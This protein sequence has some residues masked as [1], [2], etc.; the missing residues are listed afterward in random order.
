M[1][2][3][4]ERTKALTHMRSLAR[5]GANGD[6]ADFADSLGPTLKS[7]PAVGLE[8]V[9]ARI[10]QGD[11][12]RAKQ[13]LGDVEPH[14]GTPGE[15]LV[16][17][18]ES[19]SFLILERSAL[20]EAL[21][22]AQRALAAAAKEQVDPVDAAEGRRI[23]ARIQLSLGVFFE[24]DPATVARVVTELPEIAEVL[25][26]GG[27]L[28]ESMAA[29]LTYA[30]RLTGHSASLAAFD[31]IV[32]RATEL[33]MPE[34][35]AEALLRKAERLAKT[36]GSN[37]EIQ[38][39]LARAGRE[40]TAIR[41]VHG[42]VDVA[43]AQALLAVTREF[44][45][46][47]T[48]L[49]LYDKYLEIRHPRGAMVLLMD[50]SQLEH[51]RGNMPA[52]DTYRRQALDLAAKYGM[53]MMRDTFR[54]GQAD[55]LMRSNRYTEAIDLCQAA[56]A[57]ELPAYHVAAYQQLLATTYS[58]VGNV[59][60]ELRYATLAMDRFEA[61]GAMDS[62]SVVAAKLA[63]ALASLRIDEA[64]HE[65]VTLL[66]R[67]AD[68]D[69]QR[70]D[71]EEAIRKHELLVQNAINQFHVSPSPSLRIDL[72]AEAK[73][74]LTSAE[75][76]LPRLASHKAAQRRGGL[77]QLRG[78][79]LQSQGN[80]EG[81]EQAWREAVHT[82][83]S[84]GLKME[85]ANS[86]FIVGVMCLNRANEQLLPHFGEAEEYLNAAQQF[87][88][89]MGMRS[90]DAQARY[91]LA[92]LYSNAA[93]RAP[94]EVRQPLNQAALEHLDRAEVKLDAVRTEYRASSVL[95]T[96]KEKRALAQRS[97]RINELALWLSIYVAVDA[98]L[99]WNWTQRTKARAFNDTLSTRFEKSSTPVKAV[100]NESDSIF[101]LMEAFGTSSEVPR[102]SIEADALTGGTGEPPL[103]T[104]DRTESNVTPEDELAIPLSSPITGS[105]LHRILET[106][107]SGDRSFV[108][109]DW[110]AARGRLALCTLGQDGIP[111]MK[112]LDVPL[113]SVDDFVDSSLGEKT[114]RFTLHQNPELL[115]VLDSLIA[116]LVE[117]TNPGDCLI[118]CPTGSL[119]AIPLHALHLG[120]AP[121]LV[122]NPVVYSPSLSV[123]RYSLMQSEPKSLT[124][125]ALLGDPN[126]DRPTAAA[127][128]SEVGSWFGVDAVH[129]EAVT[130]ARFRE[131]ISSCGLV[132]FQG[133]AKYNRADALASEL[134][135]VDGTLTVRDVFE[136]PRVEVDL[137]TL[138]ACESA[139]T[140]VETGDEPIGL[141]PAF[142][143]TGASAVLATL[144]P[145]YQ[146]SAAETMRN[147]YRELL[148]TDT[149]MTKI[150]ALR[151]AMLAVR[152]TPGFETEYHWAAFVL[153]G[154]WR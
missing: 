54:L 86:R 95:K 23:Y 8:R 71:F 37:A 153:S 65:A 123:L 70:G 12:L 101:D 35:V 19:A 28:P 49:P 55:V 113:Q 40:F 138:A 13:A 146:K 16:L 10:R 88:E 100:E 137:L 89:E 99:T 118:L 44:A 131:A 59:P 1:N 124:T 30:E 115:R 107:C 103:N 98:K 58:F 33:A 26:Q 69:E 53:S 5:I 84:A 18:L 96:Q 66:A 122:R 134:C 50:L 117:L 102:V 41:H 38:E 76:L 36:S 62:A 24:I 136:L 148:R 125:A 132:H 63:I 109:V 79:L 128:V 78:Q 92:L 34:F 82:Y 20:R 93:S 72:L 135:F 6:A 81:A 68:L 32:W 142:L 127:L 140:L 43:Y 80:G 22:S 139:A 27:R 110:I 7:D 90:Q 114:Y 3:S 75:L 116:P 48:L 25:Q 154:D 45:A 83:E 119:H 60:E 73:A 42:P 57:E 67:W 147:F 74:S 29:R 15:R 133:H 151:A 17:A 126:G 21:D 9:R 2:S 152:A 56:L 14:L 31:D 85:A 145:V 112:T 87:Y 144:W 97:G 11:L 143:Y 150:D 4:T 120:G 52:A 105:E 77:L 46:T 39:L 141:I 108:C 91:M 121:L 61:I 104:R 94:E 47:T 130:R 111:H 129:G 149:K 64:S 51:V 106:Q